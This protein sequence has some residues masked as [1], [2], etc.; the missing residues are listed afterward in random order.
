M[1][2]TDKYNYVPYLHWTISEWVGG[3]FAVSHSKHSSELNISVVISNFSE[4]IHNWVT[5]LQKNILF[6]SYN[7]E[8][9]LK[10]F[11]YRSLVLKKWTL[12]FTQGNCGFI[13]TQKK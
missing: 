10:N 3:T 6:D 4:H 8:Y 13:L 1:L 5:Q 2:A 11:G 9:L 7:C 12:N